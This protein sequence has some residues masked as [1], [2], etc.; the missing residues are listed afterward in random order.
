[1]T[2]LLQYTDNKNHPDACNVYGLIAKLLALQLF[3]SECIDIRET[4][5][6]F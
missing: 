6:R 3:S 2:F 4:N 1:M 5:R